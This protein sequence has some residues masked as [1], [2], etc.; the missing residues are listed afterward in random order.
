MALC[1][2]DQTKIPD[3]T[4]NVT[5]GDEL[6]DIEFLMETS[7]ADAGGGAEQFNFPVSCLKCELFALSVNKYFY[8]WNLYRI[9][10]LVGSA[11]AIMAQISMN[12]FAVH[13]MHFFIIRNQLNC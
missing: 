10:A 8:F 6:N 3:E 13:A 4:Q 12:L 2:S 5:G 7:T 1:L 11:M 9:A